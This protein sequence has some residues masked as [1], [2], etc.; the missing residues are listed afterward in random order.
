MQ[1]SI[2]DHIAAVSGIGFNWLFRHTLSQLICVLSLLAWFVGIG[3]AGVSTPWV[4][5]Q[6]WMTEEY[7]QWPQEDI[8]RFASAVE[9]VM[10]ASLANLPIV[11]RAA[12]QEDLRQ[13]LQWRLPRD[14]MVEQQMTMEVEELGLLVDDYLM[15][16]PLDA[17]QRELAGQ[18]IQGIISSVRDQIEQH[19]SEKTGALSESESAMPLMAELAR[20]QKQMQTA[21]DNRL[22]IA[23]K[24]PFS[25]EE[26]QQILLSIDKTARMVLAGKTPETLR[27][28][29]LYQASELIQEI[30]RA[31]PREKVSSE[32][33]A[34]AKR[35][36]F[37]YWQKED[38]QRQ[39][40]HYAKVTRREYRDILDKL[41]DETIRSDD[42]LGNHADL[43]TRGNSQG[44]GS[45]ALS[46][47]SRDAQVATAQVP[48]NQAPQDE[49]D[50][51]DSRARANRILG[52]HRV[53]VCLVV[54]VIFSLLLGRRL[55]SR[56][57]KTSCGPR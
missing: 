50:S 10:P 44:Q 8:R 23:H 14:K 9:N 38:I 3:A 21:S 52:Q 7:E 12:L 47:L 16:G 11:E 22:C 19:V 42:M 29:S 20:V 34:E 43:L 35:V 18:Q 36:Y 46:P 55:Y 45:D 39:K 28:L 13:Y 53:T 51:P 32:R 48:A 2:E 1:N 37:N 31:V 41:A 56:G 40:E 15:R 33:L 26:F 54:G 17:R 6:Q 30:F 49:S 57:G 5:L 25:N 4:P 27:H 24:H